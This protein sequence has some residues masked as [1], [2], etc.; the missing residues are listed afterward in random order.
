MSYWLNR[1][2]IGCEMVVLNQCVKN[3]AQG[4]V[5]SDNKLVETKLLF[6]DGA[7][8]TQSCTQLTRSQVTVF[9]E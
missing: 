3:R 8:T 6:D 4:P 2:F 1:V 9:A 5:F 7:D